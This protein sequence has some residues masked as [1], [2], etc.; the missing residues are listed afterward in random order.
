VKGEA[1]PVESPSLLVARTTLFVPADRPDRYAKALGSG[2]DIV[3]VDLEDAVA[4]ANKAEARDAVAGFFTLDKR[5]HV[6][7]ALRI[8]GLGTLDG[9]RDLLHIEARAIRPDVILLPKTCCSG[10]IRALAALMRE[11]GLHCPIIAIV[12][13]AEGLENAT[14]IAMAPH[15]AAICFGSAD[16]SAE[17]GSGM[18]W[19]ALHYA[20]GRIVQ[21]AAR[22]GILA[23]DG[24]W[25]ALADADGLAAESHRLPGLGFDGRVVIH[26]SQVAIVHEAFR[27][28][29]P[30]V[31]RATKIILAAETQG[32][33]VVSVGGHMVD[34]PVIAWARRILARASP[35]VG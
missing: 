9:L 4:C 16:Y 25:L 31:E 24:A 2:A 27:P 20:R 6:C 8:N 30:D 28:N 15:V 34:R 18:H 12:E 1:L 26:P 13:T 11:I 22:A 29:D 10:D 14:D 23:L 17:T 3:C 7:R 32:E 5:S 33:G 21:A 19:D 35:G